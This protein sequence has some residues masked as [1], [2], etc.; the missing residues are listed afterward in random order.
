MKLKNKI[1]YLK[2]KTMEDQGITLELRSVGLW[3]AEFPHQIEIQLT[4]RLDSKVNIK[5]LLAIR[6][7]MSACDEK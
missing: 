4:L 7:L 6:N 2:D 1:S 5:F 3:P